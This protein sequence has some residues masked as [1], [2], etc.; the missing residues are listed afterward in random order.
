MPSSGASEDSYSV[1]R[2]NNKL[3]LKKKKKKKKKARQSI[4]RQKQ[5]NNQ[6]EQPPKIP[7]ILFC[8]G[9]LL[10]G[11]GSSLKIGLCMQ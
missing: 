8:V 11:M 7:L 5:T 10:L 6:N 4:I 3:N 1:L 2:Y 9:L